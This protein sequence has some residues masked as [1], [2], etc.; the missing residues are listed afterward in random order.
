MGNRVA[1]PAAT[2]RIAVSTLSGD[3]SW[4]LSHEVVSGP[5]NAT[6]EIKKTTAKLQNKISSER[7]SVA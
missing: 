6:P 4:M 2:K 5:V 3:K 7:I 1:T